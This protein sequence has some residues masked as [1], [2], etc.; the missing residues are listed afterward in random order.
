M[1][2]T[3]PEYAGVQTLA[4]PLAYLTAHSKHHFRASVSP[5]AQGGAELSV[6]GK[7]MKALR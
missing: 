6:D 7:M 3:S 5:L 4:K 1:K 2:T